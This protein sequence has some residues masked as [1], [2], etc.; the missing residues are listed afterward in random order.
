MVIITATKHNIF[1]N[2]AMIYNNF[3]GENLQVLYSKSKFTL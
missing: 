2:R 3:E 1:F